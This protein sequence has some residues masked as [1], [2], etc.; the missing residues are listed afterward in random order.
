MTLGDWVVVLVG[1]V[2]FGLIVGTDRRVTINRNRLVEQIVALEQVFGRALGQGIAKAKQ[3]AVSEIQ[4]RVN[5]AV[6]DAMEGLAQTLI[7]HREDLDR[8]AEGLT[9]LGADFED[10]RDVVTTMRA[11]R[12][13]P[14]LDEEQRLQL[15]VMWPQVCCRHCGAMHPGQ[16]PRV[17]EM[18]FHPGGIT[19]RVIYYPNGEWEIP[20]DAILITDVYP[21]GVPD[22]PPDED[23]A[24]ANGATA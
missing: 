5:Q 23:K 14:G 17:K 4:Q 16:C 13:V 10:L 9:S 11:P 8:N 20:P 2:L 19:S 12:V 1:V 24:A 15:R 18:R 6:A 7:D 21:G 3:E 22:M